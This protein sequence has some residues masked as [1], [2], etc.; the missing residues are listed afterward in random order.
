MSFAMQGGKK[1][2]RQ[3]DS[4]IMIMSNHDSWRLLWL[5][6]NCNIR[7]EWRTVKSKDC[8]K[9]CFQNVTKSFRVSQILDYCQQ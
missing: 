8:N 2:Q 3:N 7:R 1:K 4:K 5:H 9:Q 6:I